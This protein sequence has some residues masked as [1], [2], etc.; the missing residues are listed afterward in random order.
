MVCDIGLNIEQSEVIIIPM[1]NMYDDTDSVTTSELTYWVATAEDED[2]TWSLQ[3]SNVIVFGDDR[4]MN[5]M[6]YISDPSNEDEIVVSGL[7]TTETPY[8]P[9]DL[10]DFDV[11]TYDV[12]SATGT[13]TDMYLGAKIDSYLTVEASTL[14]LDWKNP[15][16]LV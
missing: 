12:T 5:F 6:T 11:D 1:T 3:N 13:D 15:M 8:L 10:S 9:D 4:Y 7:F 14:T 16:A 2:V